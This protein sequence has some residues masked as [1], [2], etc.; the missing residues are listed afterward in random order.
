MTPANVIPKSSPA[1]LVATFERYCLDTAAPAAALKRADYVAV[2]RRAGSTIASFVV[3]D[4]RPAVMLSDDG[5]A[6]A[7]AVASRSGQT[8]RLRAM[9]ARRFPGARPVDPARI[10]QQTEQAWAIP[11]AAGGIVFVQRLTAPAQPSQLI[12]GIQR[13][14]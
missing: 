1:Q 9:V 11:G 7:V 14:I 8:E 2:P 12:L 4:R 6:C 10:G 3:D 5:R 13:N